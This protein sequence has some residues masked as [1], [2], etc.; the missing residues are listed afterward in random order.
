MQSLQSG[1]YKIRLHYCNTLSGFY[2]MYKIR[3]YLCKL[4]SG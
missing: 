3:P 4:L 1:F 2:Y